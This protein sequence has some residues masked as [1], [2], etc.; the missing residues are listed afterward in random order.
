MRDSLHFVGTLVLLA[1]SPFVASSR[2]GEKE[3][4]MSATRPERGPY[5]ETDR[6]FM[7]PYRTRI[8]GTAVRF[9]MIPIP[10]GTFRFLLEYRGRN[11]NDEVVSEVDVVIQPFWIGQH[12]VTWAEYDEFYALREV[13]RKLANT[14]TRVVTPTNEVDAVAA[15]ST[16]SRICGPSCRFGGSIS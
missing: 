5:V 10:G 2:A 16:H 1:F 3:R 13:F 8:P 6:G 7:I 9:E 15:P 12:E 11:A 14:R 4:G